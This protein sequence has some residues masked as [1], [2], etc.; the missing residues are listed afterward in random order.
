MDQHTFIGKRKLGIT[1]ICDFTDYQGI[2]HDPLYKRYESVLSVIR[3][4]VPPK[5]AHFLAAPDYSAD[6]DAVKW[7]ID[8]W[9][10]TPER[11][12]ALSGEKLEKYRR[13][14]DETLGEYR[15]A[16]NN[17]SGEDLQIMGCVLRHIDDNF[18]Y[19]ADD[20]VFVVA[21]GMTPD[22]NKHISFGELVHEAP[23][24]E[25]HKLTFDVGEHGRLRSKIDATLNIPDG[26]VVA[27]G[28]I[29]AVEAAEGFAFAGWQPNPVGIKMT[30]DM[31]VKAQYTRLAPP[32]VVPAPEPPKPR[33]ARCRFDAGPN[34]LLKGRPEII[35]PAGAPLLPAEVP[36]VQ[37]KKGYIFKGWNLNPMNFIMNGDTLFTA[38][39]EKKKPWYARCWSWLRWLLL[40]LLLLLLGWLFFWLFPPSCLDHAINGV[41]PIGSVD[42][43]GDTIEENGFV[44]PIELEDGRLPEDEDI[45]APVYDEENGLP[46]IVEEPGMPAVIGNRLFL[47]LEDENDNIDDFAQAFKKAYPGEQ[48]SI[49]GY[50]REVKSLVVQIPENERDQIRRSINQRISNFRFIVFDEEI[51]EIHTSGASTTHETTP[52]WHLAAIKAPE[53]WQ[54]TEGSPDVIVAVVD[55]GIDPSHKIFGNRIRDPYNVFTQ[56]NR[57]SQGEGHGTHT[58]GLAVGSLEFK[59]QGAAG[60]APKCSLMP[61]QVFDNGYCPLSALVSGIMYAVHKGADVINVSI[62]PSFKGLDM[63]PIAAQEE[64]ARTQF[65]NV[66]K[67]WERVCRLAERKKSIIVFAAG[68]D[69]ILSCIPPENRTGAAISVGSV[70]HNLFPTDFTDYG[71]GTDISAPGK[72]IYS[73]I[74]GNRFESYDGTSMSAPIVSGAIALM[75]TLKKDLTVEQAWSVLYRTGKDVYGNMPPMLQV[76][77]ALDAVKRGDFRTPD[78]RPGMPVPEDMIDEYDISPVEPWIDVTPQ[79]GTTVGPGGIVVVSPADGVVDPVSG[80]VTPGQGGVVPG[81][82]GVA[83]GAG[84]VAPGAGG[85]NPGGDS[86]PG[87]PGNS[88]APGNTADDKEYLRKMLE[89]Y[90]KKVAEIEAELGK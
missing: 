75:K 10:E 78:F 83:P 18:I 73:S 52:G 67:L 55:D 44:K 77:L 39:Y 68:N 16:L 7:Y 54:I 14:K 19:C 37:P 76:N 48:Y 72:E 49:I 1:D 40:A 53:G 81:A 69:N 35:K 59:G 87:A 60:V 89:F 71:Q 32:A 2:G 13:I 90:K 24:V 30:E 11:L 12:V 28:D 25:K 29:P 43:D 21:W 65:V 34:G 33:M 41:L 63:L 56:N 31:V 79:P 9:T 70:D 82:G 20:K 85:V 4:A 45:V 58:A 80:A 26:G 74:P 51:Y 61:I 84:G 47:F 62:G 46:P 86:A 15:R 42:I 36:V 50:D 57:L 8:Q 88:G 38:V 64:I 6:Q 3:K 17:L 66:A 5:Y 23:N 22:T 27:P